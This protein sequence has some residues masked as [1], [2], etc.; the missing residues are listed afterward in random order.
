MPFL[1]RRFRDLVERQL[2][3][4]AEDQEHLL[5]ELAEARE[6]ERRSGADDVEEAF[7]DWHDR[8]DW[9]VDE[10]CE[11]RDRYASTLDD[12]T[13]REYRRAFVRG[14]RRRFPTLSP[15]LEA[16]ARFDDD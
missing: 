5:R 15:A 6:R 16:E 3:L 8:V 13:S 10:L 1:R 9:L 12:S 11:L 2:D 4:F 7:G 14:A